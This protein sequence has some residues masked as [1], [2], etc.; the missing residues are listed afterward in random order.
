MIRLHAEF[1]TEAE[2]E[3]WRDGMYRAYHPAG[4]STHITISKAARVRNGVSEQV[5]VA[6]GSRAESC[7]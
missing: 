2:A 1:D 3:L 5:W 6:Y 4:Y 7:D